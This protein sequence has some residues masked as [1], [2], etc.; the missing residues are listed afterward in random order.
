MK[1]K[2][3]VIEKIKRDLAGEPEKRDELLK[4]WELQD[5]GP[6][7]SKAPYEEALEE[8]SR[9]STGIP[10]YYAY[11][12]YSQSPDNTCG[13]A[14]IASA[15]D[16]FGINPYK[17][18]KRAGADGRYH[19]IPDEILGNVYRDF[20]PNWPVMNTVTVRET[21]MAAFSRY[22][23]KSSEAYP[24]AFSNGEDAKEWITEWISKYRLP[25]IVLLDQGSKMFGSNI[26]NFTPHWCTV[27]A[28]DNTYVSVATWEEI[29]TVSWQDFMDAW[30]CWFLPYPNNYYALHVWK[31]S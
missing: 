13:Q 10:Y 17:L 24:P 18:Q 29:I 26:K 28:Y 7:H 3:E 15:V 14:V 30:H 4:A 6:E 27:F 25:V 5:K 21:I 9:G 22:G 11:D 2:E 1:T 19:F 8:M 12:N 31:Q 23:L 20:G 16:Y